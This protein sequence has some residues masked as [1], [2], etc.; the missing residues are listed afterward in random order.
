VREVESPLDEAN[1]AHV[2]PPCAHDKPFTSTASG[3]RLP[4]L[5]RRATLRCRGPARPLACPIAKY[6]GPVCECSWPDPAFETLERDFPEIPKGEALPDAE[7]AN[8]VRYQALFRL[9]MGT[10]QPFVGLI[11]RICV[12]NSWACSERRGARTSPRSKRSHP[13]RSRR[14]NNSAR[15]ARTLGALQ[16]RLR[17]AQ[18][19]RRLHFCSA[20]GPRL[21]AKPGRRS[22]LLRGLN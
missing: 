16:D 6:H 1:R 8:H 11:L 22:G 21:G 18:R 2:S 9:R 10:E 5:A 3:S 12:G 19:P 4:M 15:R 17:R 20:A 7:L 14:R 13:R